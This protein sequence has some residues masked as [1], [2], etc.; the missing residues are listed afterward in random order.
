MLRERTPESKATFRAA[1]EKLADFFFRASAKQSTISAGARIT[2]KNLIA[3][4]H[5]KANYKYDEFEIQTRYRKI[6]TSNPVIAS[7]VNQNW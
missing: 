4:S 5:I 3:K 6:N 2:P 1:N 7:H